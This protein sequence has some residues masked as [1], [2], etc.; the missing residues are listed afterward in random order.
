VHWNASSKLGFL[1]LYYFRSR[2][3][4]STSGTSW[5]GPKTGPLA[6]PFLL[7]IWY[8]HSSPNTIAS[9]REAVMFMRRGD[10][11]SSCPSRYQTGCWHGS[12]HPLALEESEFCTMYFLS[13]GSRSII[14]VVS[15]RSQS[16]IY[17]ARVTPTGWSEAWWPGGAW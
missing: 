4:I 16:F 5:L 12:L 1:N 13:L 15:T 11:A 2:C 17:S 14:A 6:T 10:W 7:V 9:W 8:P 3:F